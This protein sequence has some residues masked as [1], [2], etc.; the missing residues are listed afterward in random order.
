MAEVSAEV[1]ADQVSLT[2]RY[3]RQLIDELI[4]S[5]HLRLISK[6]A[7]RQANLY[8]IGRVVVNPSSL[9]GV[10]PSSLLR[11]GSTEVA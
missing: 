8:A 4:K 3:V 1:L 10:N 2:V 11:E 6:G 9:R 7:G 5:G